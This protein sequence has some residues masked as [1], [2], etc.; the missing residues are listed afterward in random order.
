M[1]DPEVDP[2]YELVDIT[3]PN[4]CN[5]DQADEHEGGAINSASQQSTNVENSSLTESFQNQTASVD[6]MAPSQNEPLLRK[7]SGGPANE[8]LSAPEKEFC[9]D[10]LGTSDSTDADDDGEDE[11]A[12]TVNRSTSVEETPRASTQQRL[13]GKLKFVLAGYLPKDVPEQSLNKPDEL[14]RNLLSTL[15]QTLEGKTFPAELSQADFSI[16]CDCNYSRQ[17]ENNWY[18]LGQILHCAMTELDKKGVMKLGVVTIPQVGICYMPNL[19][20]QLPSNICFAG[21]KIPVKGTD[22]D[23]VGHI[24]KVVA[25]I[26][27][28][29]VPTTTFTSPK[30]A[31]ADLKDKKS[32]NWM[33]LEKNTMQIFLPCEKFPVIKFGRHLLVGPKTKRKD[34]LQ[35]E[36]RA[37]AKRRKKSGTSKVPKQQIL[38]TTDGTFDPIQQVSERITAYKYWNLTSIHE[39]YKYKGRGM[40]VAIVD[41]GVAQSHAAFKTDNPAGSKILFSKNFAEEALD[42][43]QDPQGHG[44]FCA[45]IICGNSFLAYENPNGRDGKQVQVPPG[46]APEAKL[47][48]CKVT[49]GDKKDVQVKAVVDALKYIKD[50]Y[51]GPK[52]EHKVDVVSL[53]FTLATYSEEVATAISDLVCRRVIVVCAASNLGHTYETSITYPARFGNVL[54]IGSDSGH[55][56]P[57]SF[58]PVG[59]DLDFLAP[60]EN[61]LSSK[62]SSSLGYSNHAECGS[63]TSFAAPAV[64]GLICLILECLKKE[65]RSEAEKFHNHFVMKD[66]LRKMSTNGSTHSN[67]RGFGTLLPSQFFRNPDLIVQ[68]LKM[69]ILEGNTHIL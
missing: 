54:C 38:F 69:D 58:S 47:V 21:I 7:R 36:T 22:E 39:R 4:E 50:N 31:F 20:E 6:S 48:V 23:V 61:I 52:A 41:T 19:L 3:D 45:G 59:Q 14:R 63:G 35:V 17:L 24:P 5:S 30:G 9:G 12:A 66:L 25:A 28:Y 11:D 65:Y 27:P 8:S 10:P 49:H 37:M 60:G 1:A 64:A 43:S 15:E 33:Q 16:G 2:S 46:V 42:C 44:T 26:K 29:K 68:S 51:T 56:K 18:S 34:P 62:S 40:V 67:E 32:H 55:G 57:S 13:R 53:S